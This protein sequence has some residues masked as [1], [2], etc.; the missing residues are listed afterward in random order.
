MAN[1]RFRAIYLQRKRDHLK[2][3]LQSY[4]GPRRTKNHALPETKVTSWLI[5][6]GGKIKM[7]QEWCG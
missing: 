1:F 2:H 3:L 5:F 7:H 4:A 6:L